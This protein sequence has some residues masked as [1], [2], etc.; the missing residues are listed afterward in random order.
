MSGIAW[1]RPRSNGV[2]R[3]RRRFFLRFCH[4]TSR[5]DSESCDVR[6]KN[7]A[8]HLMTPLVFV[9]PPDRGLGRRART[10]ILP[11]PLCAATLVVCTS[12]VHVDVLRPATSH[13]ARV[14]QSGRP[15]TSS[16]PRTSPSPH[17][18]PSLCYA[19]SLVVSH[20]LTLPPHGAPPCP[21]TLCATLCPLRVP[22]DSQPVSQA[23][24]ASGSD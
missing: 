10:H 18:A 4:S 12:V 23:T 11:V 5:C 22:R 16:T 14:T 6:C 7:N 15:S 21:A 1:Q 8:V 19:A 2:V 9:Q 3:G 13:L 17:P 24:L 20:S